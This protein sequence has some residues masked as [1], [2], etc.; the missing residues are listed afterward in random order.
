[1]Y[2]HSKVDLKHRQV[3]VDLKD[4]VDVR[5]AKEEGTLHATLLDRRM[6]TKSDRYC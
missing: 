2:Q 1:M 3:V 5:K 4:T 6:K